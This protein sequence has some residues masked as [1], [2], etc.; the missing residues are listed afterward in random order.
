MAESYRV[1]KSD[2]LDFNIRVRLLFKNHTLDANNSYH[3]NSILHSKNE[4]TTEN[5]V[6]INIFCKQVIALI[7]FYPHSFGLLGKCVH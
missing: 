1:G 7:P 2:S 5:E 4:I 3:Y 6:V